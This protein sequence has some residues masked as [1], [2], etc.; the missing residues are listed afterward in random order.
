MHD[1]LTDQAFRVQLDTPYEEA[2]ERTRA[3]LQAEGF[4]VITEIDIQ[5]TLKEKIGADFR[6]YAILGACNP[7]IAHRALSIEREIGL[8][9]P[10]NVI[11]YE[12]EG[13]PGTVVS[14]VDPMAML[15]DIEEPELQSIADDA[16]AR[17]ARV[18]QA[19]AG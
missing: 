11:V 9:L 2:L 16:H 1:P 13:Q 19:L 18:A 3:A 7:S 15:A 14:I 6:K 5:S 12:A 4:G 10:C 8:L 17:L